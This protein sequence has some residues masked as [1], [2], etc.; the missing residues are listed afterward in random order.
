[1][2]PPLRALSALLL[3]VGVVSC[4]ESP[5]KLRQDR[6]QLAFAPHFSAN[7]AAIYRSLAAFSVTLDN[8]HV[9]VRAA[10]RGDALGTL[11]EDTTIAF[12]AAAN[13][14]TIDIELA[15]ASSEQSVTATVELRQGTT[16]YFQGAESLLARLGE[17]TSAPEAVEMS[18][19]GPGARA[20]SL[21]IFP[22]ISTQPVTLAPL[23]STTFN[24]QARD[25]VGNVV[26]GLPVTWRIVDSS[27]ATVSPDGLVTAT[28]KA[29]ST[30]LIAT[31]LNGVAAQATL[32]VQPV[33]QLVVVRGDN[34]TGLVGTALPVSTS[35]QA[36]AANGHFVAGATINFTAI[37]GRGSVSQSSVTTDAGGIATTTLTLGQAI[38]SYT[39]T[40]TVAATPSIVT[41][42]TA[43]A[44]SGAAAALGIVSGNSQA[45]TVKATLGQSLSV[46]ATDSFGNPVSGQSVTF[47]VTSGRALLLALAAGAAPASSVT[48]TT[49]SD[50]IAAVSLVA[51]T[52]AG[53]VGVTASLAQS[54]IAPASFAETVKPGAPVQLVM[55]QQPAQKAQATLPLGRQPKVQV[56]DQFGNAVALPGVAVDVTEICTQCGRTVAPKGTRPSLNRA[57]SPLRSRAVISPL[58]PRLA[59]SAQPSVSRLAVPTRISRTTSISDTITRGVVGKTQVLTDAN[60]VASFTDLALNEFVGPYELELLP[61]S[62]H[63]AVL[64]PAFSDVID[65]SAGPAAAIIAW[66]L[67]D[68]AIVTVLPPDTL[69]PS[70]RV[71]DKVGNGIGGVSVSW[72]VTDGASVFDNSNTTASSQTDANGIA[73]P[74]LWILPAGSVGPFTIVASPGGPPLENAPLTLTALLEIPNFTGVP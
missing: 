17:T 52:L 19:V 55:L 13:E 23:G 72:S 26:A 5:T 51:D 49:G 15:L 39:F 73:R 66:D 10:P 20:T 61:D 40:A 57:P 50:G 8:V 25:A 34:Q 53:P 58:T 47:S 71:I 28:S 64:A 32:D 31:G 33:T 60:G 62:A 59:A 69:S 70:V 4:S 6:L 9:V 36:L 44:T 24:T 18:Y 65:L 22:T 43:T 56:A 2:R 12:P 3:A 21:G 1:M 30:T 37:D 35:V 38:G 27:I 42:V 45:D 74:G 67:T 48:V 63:A 7:A 16:V 68:T 29:G 11:L 46:K 54:T 14:V 41:R